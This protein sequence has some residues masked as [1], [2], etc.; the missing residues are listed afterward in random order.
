MGAVGLATILTVGT[1]VFWHDAVQQHKAWRTIFAL[2][3][4]NGY[5]LCSYGLCSYGLLKYIA[6]AQG[7][8]H[9]LRAV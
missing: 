3:D 7:V 6:M 9:Y 2:F 4:I 1:A 8:A 5:G